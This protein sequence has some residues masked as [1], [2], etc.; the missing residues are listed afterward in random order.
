MI[1]QNL[2]APSMEDLRTFQ[3]DNTDQITISLPNSVPIG[4]L[5]VRKGKTL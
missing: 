1:F 5:S 2:D 3:K 4:F